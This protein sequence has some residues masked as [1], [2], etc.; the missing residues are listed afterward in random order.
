MD[1]SFEQ[2]AFTAR[3]GLKDTR[4]ALQLADET[5]TPLPLADIIRNRFLINQNRGRNEH[6]WTS[7]ARVI[8]EENNRS[9]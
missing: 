3:L 7:I 2:P 6:D 4:L 9:E 5:S 1:E 8:A